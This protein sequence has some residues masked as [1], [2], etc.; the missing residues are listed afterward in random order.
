MDGVFDIF[1]TF[2]NI[3]SGMWE[4]VSNFIFPYKIIFIVLF[5]LFLVIY[6]IIMANFLYIKRHDKADWFIWGGF[7]LV[8]IIIS[9]ITMPTVWLAAEIILG[10]LLGVYWF[11]ADKTRQAK[12]TIYSNNL[13][14][15]DSSDKY[16]SKDKENNDRK[17]NRRRREGKIS[18]KF[19]FSR[20]HWVLGVPVLMNKFVFRISTT[21]TPEQISKMVKQLSDYYTEYN[22]RH[23]RNKRGIKYEVTAEVKVSKNLVVEFDEQISNELPWYVVPMGAIDVSNKGTAKAT[24]YT[25]MLHDPKDEGKSFQCLAKTTTAPPAP[26]AFVVGS[27]GGGKS[28]LLNTIIAHFVNKAKQDRQTEL[29]LCDA[30]RVEF[31]PYCSLNEVAGVAVTLE[32]AVDLTTKFREQMLERN[33][34][35]EK[36]GIKK[37]PLDGHVQLQRHINLNGHLIAGDT[38]IEFKTS[39]GQVHKDYALN[40]KGRNDITEINIPEPEPEEEEDKGGGGFGW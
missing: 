25:W 29:Y 28:V 1:A 30:K 12:T 6:R 32:E 15:E 35:M 38:V 27:T 9:L 31:R 11:I 3:L 5:F 20:M 17:E 19:S 21:C 8:Q 16:D 26:Q 40:L 18:R 4:T 34:M 10:I 22:W 2:G 39:D 33:E 7:V 13:V 23:L 14:Y 24:P 37:I 36:E